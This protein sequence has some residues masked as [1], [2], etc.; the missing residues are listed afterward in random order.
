VGYDSFQS[1][2]NLP[3]FRSNL[4]PPPLFSRLPPPPPFRTPNMEAVLP[5]NAGKFYQ[6]KRNYVQQGSVS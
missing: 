4:L 5:S 1:G 2:T 6:A 3:A